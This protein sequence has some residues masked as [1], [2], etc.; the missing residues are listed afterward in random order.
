MNQ[1]IELK[2]IVVDEKTE[3]I[4]KAVARAENVTIDEAISIVCLPKSESQKRAV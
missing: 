2:G 3:A 4:I 1:Q